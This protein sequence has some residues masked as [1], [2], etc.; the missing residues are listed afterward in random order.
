MAL[1][2]VK[3]QERLDNPIERTNPVNEPD[4]HHEEGYNPFDLTAPSV[5]T[6]R[7]GEVTPISVV[8]TV[9]ADRHL[10]T[11]GIK[12][13]MDQIQDRVMNE[14]RAYV[15]YFHVPLQC[16]YPYNYDKII[17]NPTKGDDVPFKALPAVPLA[18]FFRQFFFGE[19]VLSFSNS[20]Y[21][22][23]E[24]VLSHFDVT[25]LPTYTALE[26]M[27]ASSEGF[28]IAGNTVW[29]HIVRN[30][31]NLGAFL[32][33]CFALSRGQLLDNLDFALDS[34][35]IEYKHNYKTYQSEFQSHID[36]VFNRLLRMYQVDSE[37]P[38][39]QSYGF[40]PYILGIDL[41]EAG[42]NGLLSSTFQADWLSFTTINSVVKVSYI[43]KVSISDDGITSN[44]FNLSSFRAALY[45]CF[46]KGLFPFIG[47]ISLDSNSYGIK[48]PMGFD[49]E[50]KSHY[51]FFKMYFDMFPLENIDSNDFDEFFDAGFINPSRVVAYQQIVA[52][53]MTSDTVDNVFSADL[54]MQNIR[55]IMF[56]SYDG[57]TQEPT[58][59]YNGVDYEY[60]LFTTGAW[61]RAWFSEW[62]SSSFLPRLLPFVSNVF[63]QRRSLRFKDYFSSAR[64]NVLAVGDL[65]IPV[66]DGSVSPVDTTRGI[67]FQ[68]YYNAVNRW[69]MKKKKQMA[70]LFGVVPTD[71]EIKPSYIVRRVNAIGG[72]TVSN[73]ADNQGKVST[74]LVSTTSDYAFDVFLDDFGILM[75]LYTLDIV[76]YYP[77]G[78]DRSYRSIDRLSLYNPMLQNIGDQ[79]I[80]RDEYTGDIT[81]SPDAPFGYV[82]RYG[83]LKQGIAR[84]HGGFVNDIPAMAFVYPSRSAFDVDSQGSLKI[85]PD[86]IR[87][88]PFYLDKFK[89]SLT[90]VSPAQYYHF[91]LS[92][93]NPHKSARKIAMWPGIL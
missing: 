52:E 23:V 38:S 56:P 8:D 81:F 47:G 32:Y 89:D 50:L 46:E 91:A 74:N 13:F 69:G 6:A 60:D 92:V 5:F 1:N 55:S 75:G 83:H 68:R 76:P 64:P 26:I 58:F 7:Y 45:D 85:S 25:S 22:N 41:S 71:G 54:W 18:H 79:E 80:R 37:D 93:N 61:E 9:P 78:V 57:L 36:A 86:F 33:L 21:G 65:Q 39:V 87:D 90:G 72:D 28:D 10:V 14:M 43:P 17:T 66:T 27:Q 48:V 59:E 49:S 88:Q 70:S 51:E 30:N 29:Q 11:E 62:A 67:V 84:A 15:D 63:F 12:S 53:H 73:T 40:L 3:R 2:P 19:Y 4:Y 24:V 35:P 77:A 34:T 82:T 16:I 20:L 31:I 44:D 42:D